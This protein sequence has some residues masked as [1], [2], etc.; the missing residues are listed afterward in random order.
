MGS[1]A[2][3][4]VLANPLEFESVFVSHGSDGTIL[5]TKPKLIPGTHWLSF[6]G[7]TGSRAGIEIFG[8][9][10]RVRTVHPEMS[11]EIHLYITD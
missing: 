5:A 10:E 6:E 3:L 9:D 8:T 1:A 7:C 11:S 2:S 4:V